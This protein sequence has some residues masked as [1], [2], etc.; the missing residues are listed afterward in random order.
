MG[1]GVWGSGT[2]GKELME[3][4]RHTRIDFRSREQVSRP[5][6]CVQNEKRLMEYT[7]KCYQGL[8]LG[9]GIKGDNNEIISFAYL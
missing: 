1:M 7:P 6:L 9:H 3:T 4:N 5:H 2:K 8:F